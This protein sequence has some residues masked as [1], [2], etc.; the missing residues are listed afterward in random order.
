MHWS[1][2]DLPAAAVLSRRR[3]R[4]LAATVALLVAALLALGVGGYYWLR[5]EAAQPPTVDLTEVERPA[6][7]EIEEARAAVSRS[8]RSAT[9]WGWLGVVLL[10][11]N[12]PEA[13]DCFAVAERLD[14]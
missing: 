2:R 11:H 9:A 4:T 3:R 12:F 10:A 14:P 8:P 13:T 6:V 7:K 1:S 5:V